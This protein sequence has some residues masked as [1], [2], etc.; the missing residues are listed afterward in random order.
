MRKSE[1]H[2]CY[3]LVTMKR[4]KKLT[5]LLPV[6]MLFSFYGPKATIEWDFVEHDFGKIAKNEP[7]TI[8]FVFK[9]PGMIPLVVVDVKSSCGCTVPDYPKAPIPPGSE[10]SITV[11]FDA[12]SSGYFSKTITVRTN[13]EEGVSE[14]FIKGIV[15]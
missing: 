4:I 11:T 15:N 10:G 8:D 6:L 9:N 2:N 13:T 12:K 7:V 1:P 3:K 14:L 5:F